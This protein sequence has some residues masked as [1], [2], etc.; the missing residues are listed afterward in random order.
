MKITVFLGVYGVYRDV[1][2]YCRNVSWFL[3]VFSDEV[4]KFAA[5]SGVYSSAARVR[6]FVLILKY[7]RL[8][9]ELPM[10]EVRIFRSKLQAKAKNPN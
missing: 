2:L 10:H 1:I 7:T 4:I 8:A 6:S 9:R 3:Q 5:N